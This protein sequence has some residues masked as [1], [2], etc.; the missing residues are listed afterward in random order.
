MATQITTKSLTSGFEATAYIGCDRYNGEVQRGSAESMKS[1]WGINQ[2]DAK[3]K[4]KEC[5]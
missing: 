3:A 2:E 1:V 4:L 5:L